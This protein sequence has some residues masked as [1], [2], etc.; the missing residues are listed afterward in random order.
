M[1][2]LFKTSPGFLIYGCLEVMYIFEFELG[3]IVDADLSWI[4]LPYK[5]R[6][7]LAEVFLFFFTTS[8][9]VDLIRGISLSVFI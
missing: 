6:L 3:T 1:I 8:T 7:D 5:I 2:L 4:E 9:D